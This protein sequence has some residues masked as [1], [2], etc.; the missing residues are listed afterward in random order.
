MTDDTHGA[1]THIHDALKMLVLGNG[2]HP[3]LLSLDVVESDG[4]MPRADENVLASGMEGQRADRL[5]ILKIVSKQ[6]K[7]HESAWHLLLAANKRPTR[8]LFIARFTA[9]FEKSNIFMDMSRLPEMMICSRGWNA[10][11]VTS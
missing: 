5:D 11:H 8:M 4:G 6:S 3:A 9:A 7:W 1:A 10:R 2:R